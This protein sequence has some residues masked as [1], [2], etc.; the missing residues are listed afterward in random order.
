MGPIE[1]LSDQNS[2]LMSGIDRSCL[3]SHFAA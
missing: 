3:V 2:L 1:M